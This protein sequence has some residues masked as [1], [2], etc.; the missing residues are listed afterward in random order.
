MYSGPMSRPPK[1]IC[2]VD[3]GTSNSVVAL[4]GADERPRFVQLEP[5]AAALLERLLAGQTLRAAL[6]GACEALGEAL[7][8]NI[9]ASTA[10]TLA[11]LVDRHIL[12]GGT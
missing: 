5:R 6:F 7:D 4:L 10:L 11:D 9:L 8:D 2:G 12:L 3:F 1:P